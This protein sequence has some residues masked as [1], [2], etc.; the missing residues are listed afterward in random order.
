M[1]SAKV[2]VIIPTYNQAKYVGEAIQS[3]FDQSCQNWELIIVDDGSTDKTR[4]IVESFSDSRIRYIYQANKGLPGARN[5]GIAKSIGRYL[6][7]L[8]ADDVYH[9]EKLCAQVAHLER[10]SEIGLSYSSRTDIDRQNNPL[11]LRRAPEQV[12]LKELVLGYPFVINDILVRREWVKGI[13]GFDESFVLN[14]EDR[15]FYLRL[16]LEGCRF[17]RVDR[18]LAYR[19]FHACRIFR[20]IPEKMATYFRAIE[21]AFSDPRCPREV[22]VLRDL[23][24]AEHYLTWGYQAAAQQE[25][26]LAHQYLRE[27]IRLNPKLLDN[28]AWAILRFFTYASTRDGGDHEAQLKEAFYCLPPELAGLSKKLEWAIARGYLARGANDLMWGR[29]ERGDC[30]LTRAIEL[31]AQLDGS[32][33]S[34]L[35]D[36]L[37]NYELGFGANSAS[38]ALQNLIPYLK[39]V[40]TR[41]EVRWLRGRFFTNR[42]F[43][44]YHLGKYRE[45]RA[46]ILKAISADLA[47]LTNRG[48]LAIMVRAAL[49]I[50]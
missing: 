39:E 7:F 37:F 30:H 46:Y 8:D 43:R 2:S 28:E 19:R 38:T 18:F 13:G 10:N 3:V 25:I 14:S 35:L 6:A 45:M 33:L 31:G 36:Q 12:S 50:H 26:E 21:T 24:Y 47:N 32:Y 34:T 40:G 29:L 15:D 23:I 27:T 41:R 44:E 5:T 11:T 4:E 48:V 42:A 20:D 9:P 16:A 17:G 49:H 22:L 1:K